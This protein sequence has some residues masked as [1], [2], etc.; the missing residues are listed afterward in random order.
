MVKECEARVKGI[1]ADEKTNLID[2]ALKLGYKHIASRREINHLFKNEALIA[3]NDSMLRFRELID[4]NHYDIAIT[5]KIRK[6]I[7]TIKNSEEKNVLL[8][9]RNAAALSELNTTLQ[10]L[11]GV[12]LPN[13]IFDCDIK[14]LQKLAEERGFTETYNKGRHRDYYQ[15]PKTLLCIDLFDGDTTFTAELEAPN[16]DTLIQAFSQLG[17]NRDCFEQHVVQPLVTSRSR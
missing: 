10:K 1:S 6:E 5:L 7:S 9:E 15:G 4:N 16:K 14:G 13:N 3:A 12:I 17:I 2:K 11:T 8:S